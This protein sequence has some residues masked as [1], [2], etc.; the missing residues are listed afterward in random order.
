MMQPR[1]VAP[2][3]VI[4]AADSAISAAASTPRVSYPE[5]WRTECA[6]SGFLELGNGVE[7]PGFREQPAPEYPEV[8]RSLRANG[9]L[10]LRLLVSADGNVCDAYVLRGLGPAIDREILSAVKKWRF[11]PSTKNGAPVAVVFTNTIHV[12]T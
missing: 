3:S 1:V 6:E 11:T 4:R 2:A 7:H 10:Y 12:R 8:L 5:P 9:D